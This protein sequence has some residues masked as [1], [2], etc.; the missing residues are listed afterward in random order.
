M[1]HKLEI[2]VHSK[3]AKNPWL[4]NIIKL[5]YQYVCVLFSKK[6]FYVS[7]PYS[8]RHN[9]FF[10]FHDKDPWSPNNVFMLAHGFSGTGNEI[11]NSTSDVEIVLFGGENWLEKQVIAISSAWNWQQ[12]S[13]LQWID[14]EYIIFNDFNNSVLHS[15]ILNVK[16]KEEVEHE[17]PVSA[18]NRPANLYASSCFESF[19]KEMPGYGYLFNQ[20]RSSINRRTELLLVSLNTGL[21]VDTIDMSRFSEA[22]TKHNGCISH[23]QF[24][25]D[26]R[27]CA[28]LVRRQYRGSRLYSE[29]WIFE[30]KSWQSTLWL[31]PFGG[32]VSHF[33]FIGHDILAY[34]CDS[35]KVDGFYE[36]SLSRKN[37]KNVTEKYSDRDG[38]PGF[39]GNQ[40]S[41]DTY[42]DGSRHKKLFV[43]GAFEEKVEEIGEIF[44]PLNFN[45]VA[46]V[47]LHPRLRGDGKFLSFDCVSGG[48]RSM[49]VVDLSDR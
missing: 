17:Y 31:V 14:N 19:A 10:G 26:G 27:Y 22:L 49:C 6:R 15:R 13:E 21:P 18:V 33:C 43:R 25:E 7:Y 28:F 41:L 5:C 40:L 11:I 39:R 42:P 38:H 2:F 29:M 32:M 9:V 48:V 20:D 30:T 44:L 34:A 1:R 47:D 45:G 36:V 12:G 24:S 4:K 16:T 8:L 3:L 46:R 35:N 23:V 37:I